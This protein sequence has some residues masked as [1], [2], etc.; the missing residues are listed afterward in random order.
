MIIKAKHHWLVDAFFKYYT[1][2]KIKTHF[3]QVLIQ[4]S[5]ENNGSPM[6]VLANHFSWWDGFWIHYLNTTRLKR[7]FHFMMLEEQLRKYWLLQYAGGFSIKK[8]SRSALETIKHT[9]DLLQDSHNLVLLFPQGEIQ[10]MH[11]IRFQFKKGV[12]TILRRTNKPVQILFIANLV[13]YF[14]H[15][16]P[17]LFMYLKEYQTDGIQPD[18]LETAFNRFFEQCVTET[19]QKKNV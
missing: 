19:R 1:I 5:C 17:T 10:S 4:G 3:H 9:T 15:P 8:G 7:R 11:P 14:S 2:W 16:R 6:L 12:E 18:H 13:E